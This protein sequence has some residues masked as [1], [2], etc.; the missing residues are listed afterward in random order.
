MKF[1]EQEQKGWNSDHTYTMIELTNLSPPIGSKL[2]K[3]YSGIQ[4]YRFNKKIIPQMG[5]DIDNPAWSGFGSVVSGVT[6]F[7][8]DRMLHLLESVREATDQNNAAW[9]RIAL[10]LGWRTWDVGAENE[11][12]EAI[13]NQGKKETRN[14]GRRKKESRP[15]N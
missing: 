10:L 2:R 11:E 5:F 7:P 4:T 1:M 3:I 14:K 6:N 9:Q 13:K 8:L 15:K 12:V